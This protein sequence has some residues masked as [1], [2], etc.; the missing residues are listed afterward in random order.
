MADPPGCPQSIPC[1][2][3]LPELICPK[4]VSEDCLYLNVFSP[5]NAQVYTIQLCLYKLSV[6]LLSSCKQPDS[7]IPVMVFFHGGNFLRVSESWFTILKLNFSTFLG[8]IKW[9]GACSFAQV[10]IILIHSLCCDSSTLESCLFLHSAPGALTTLS[11]SLSSSSLAQ[12]YSGGLLYDGQYIANTSNTIVVTVNYRLGAIGFLVFGK[13]SNAIEGNYGF[14]VRLSVASI[15]L[16][17]VQILRDHNNLWYQ[18]LTSFLT[19]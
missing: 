13:G 3:P 5:L 9:G 18:P 4:R 12:G 11:F 17:N 8:G 7:K 19:T 14:K 16:L 2:L 6:L 15:I 1:V 10:H